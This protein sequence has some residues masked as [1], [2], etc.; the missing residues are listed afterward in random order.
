MYLLTSERRT[1]KKINVSP[2]SHIAVENLLILLLIANESLRKYLQVVNTE[3]QKSR[4]CSFLLPI[5]HDEM[6]SYLVETQIIISFFRK[7]LP[8]I[9]FIIT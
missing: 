3:S 7:L 1:L 6:L 8:P 2:V 4:H 9:Q 5:T